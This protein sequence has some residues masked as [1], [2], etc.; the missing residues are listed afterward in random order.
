MGDHD[1]GT[2]D[3]NLCV[4][5]L[6]YTNGRRSALREAA[7]TATDRGLGVLAH[8]LRVWAGRAKP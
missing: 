2:H 3:T 8:D 4:E 7:D 1:Y 6:G 5:C